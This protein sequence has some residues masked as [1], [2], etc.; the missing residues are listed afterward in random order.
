MLKGYRQLQARL[1]AASYTPDILKDVQIHGVANAKKK[2]HRRTSNLGRTIR[3]GMVAR[4]HVSIYA[5]GTRNVG[6]AAAEELGRRAVTIRPR[7]GRTGRNGRPAAL[8]WGGSRTLSGRL[9]AGASPT[10][11]ARVVHQPARRGHPYLGPGL[12]DA[13]KERMGLAIVGLWN[14]AA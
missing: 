11:F 3:P 12:Q 4:N 7:P 8:A 2:V 10:S 1:K 14:G 13:A 5:G 6:Y 9:R